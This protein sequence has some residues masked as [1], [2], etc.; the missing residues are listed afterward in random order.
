M[1]MLWAL[2]TPHTILT[3]GFEW[4]LYHMVDKLPVM[5]DV[6]SICG[7]GIEMRSWSCVYGGI[8]QCGFFLFFLVIHLLFIK[9][10]SSNVCCISINLWW[11]TNK[12]QIKNHVF[13]MFVLSSSPNQAHR[14]NL[15]VRSRKWEYNILYGCVCFNLQT[16]FAIGSLATYLNSYYLEWRLWKWNLPTTQ[17]KKSNTPKLCPK[18]PRPQTSEHVV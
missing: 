6:I 11:N 18:I 5:K 2:P 3:I 12:N 16:T 10:T 17:P 8:I 14:S 15:G 1:T 13:I 7:V 4:E 9:I